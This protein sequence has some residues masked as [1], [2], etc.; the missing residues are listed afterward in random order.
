MHKHKSDIKVKAGLLVKY[1]N[2]LYEPDSIMKSIQGIIVEIITQNDSAI[3]VIQAAYWLKLQSNILRL[4]KN[5]NLTTKP[6]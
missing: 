4:E 5:V 1:L 2:T 6:R 3:I